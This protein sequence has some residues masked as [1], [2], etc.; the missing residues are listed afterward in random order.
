MKYC[1]IGSGGREHAL[2]SSL[3]NSNNINLLLYEN[4]LMLSTK[5]VLSLHFLLF[6]L[7]YN[8]V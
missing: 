7:S 2:C 6:Q 4:F 5:N 3:K 1:I 8:N